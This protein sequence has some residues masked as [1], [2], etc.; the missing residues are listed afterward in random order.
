VAWSA[1]DVS[2]S[3]TQ[4]RFCGPHS[5]VSTCVFCGTISRVY[6]TFQRGIQR[7]RHKVSLQS[8]LTSGYTHEIRGGNDCAEE[9]HEQRHGY[10]PEE[11][12]FHR[13]HGDEWRVLLQDGFDRGTGS[14]QANANDRGHQ[15]GTGDDSSGRSIGSSAGYKGLNGTRRLTSRRASRRPL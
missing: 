14:T 2:T 12:M 8:Q 9:S 11:A 3:V 15:V 4:A 6:C 10:Q 5:D 13:L 1:D 7:Q